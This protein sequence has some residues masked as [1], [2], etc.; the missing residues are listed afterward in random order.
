MAKTK[1]ASKKEK[2]A[3]GELTGKRKS[4]KKK[5]A[6]PIDMMESQGESGETDDFDVGSFENVFGILD[7]I[8]SNGKIPG[9]TSSLDEGLTNNLVGKAEMLLDYTGKKA[10][11]TDIK[12]I[13]ELSGVIASTKYMKPDENISTME[14][15]YR[16]FVDVCDVYIND[17]NPWTTVG[18]Q[19]LAIVKALRYQADW[20]RLLIKRHREDV[21]VTDHQSISSYLD[22]CSKAA[23]KEVVTK[24]V[25]IMRVSDQDKVKEAKDIAEIISSRYGLS[26]KDAEILANN[27]GAIDNLEKY[28][29]GTGISME[30]IEKLIS[31][32]KDKRKGLNKSVDHQGRDTKNKEKAIEYA[33][34]VLKVDLSKSKGS[35]TDARYVANQFMLDGDSEEVL[36]KN[37]QLLIDLAGKGTESTKKAWEDMYT[38]YL[39]F[40]L[41]KFDDRSP[42]YILSHY[43]ELNRQ[44][45]LGFIFVRH[46]QDG[47]N[48]AGFEVADDQKADIKALY[49][50]YQSLSA[51]LTGMGN[52]FDSDD[53]LLADQDKVNVLEDIIK[54][55]NQGQ[56]GK[57]F[58]EMAS[59]DMEKEQ[60]HLGD[61]KWQ[62]FASQMMMMHFD[63]ALSTN[64]KAIDVLRQNFG[65]K[66][67]KDPQD[68]KIKFQELK[69]KK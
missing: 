59:D 7:E 6:S 11:K 39:S 47:L 62:T 13:I 34:N 4:D 8:P 43:E 21:P 63:E 15:T 42:K 1:F 17:R 54:A 29:G 49:D 52:L 33:K 48:K 66:N 40:D 64:K 10:K 28:M 57:T 30:L 44:V 36:Q 2:D 20:E 41:S 61:G 65:W 51:Y 22:A 53:L 50:F 55:R 27:R 9:I 35:F 24:P 3:F 5:G 67:E 56:E 18:K 37:A 16:E 25:N 38:R 26:A 32:V 14:K 58:Y 60:K 31:Q 69:E 23:F 46:F 45:Y 68:L 19:R 12:K